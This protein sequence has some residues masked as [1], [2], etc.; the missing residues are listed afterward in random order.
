M[1]RLIREARAVR[2]SDL[3]LK[4]GQPP[5]VRVDGALT[6]LPG[7]DPLDRA[8]CDRLCRELLG[9]GLP[10]DGEQDFAVTVEG[11]RLRVNLFRAQGGVCAA[12]RLLSDEIP[13]LE[14]LGLPSGAMELKNLSRGIVL[15]TRADGQ[16]KIHHPRRSFERD[17]P[18]PPLPYSYS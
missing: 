11:T 17:Q 7:Y 12:V 14:A 2:A 18:H 3:H 1:Q 16:R 4:A 9:A 5:T 15:V 8:E 10:G 6:A 13:A